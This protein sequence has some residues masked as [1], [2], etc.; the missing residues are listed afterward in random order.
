M[1]FAALMLEALRSRETVPAAQPTVITVM[2]APRIDVEQATLTPVH[3]GH[4]EHK[5]IQHHHEKHT[6]QVI[7]F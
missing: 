7:S 6:G 4:A 2:Q 5:H 1:I 3:H